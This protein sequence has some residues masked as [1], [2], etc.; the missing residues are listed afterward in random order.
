LVY[1]SVERAVNDELN[2]SNWLHTAVKISYQQLLNI[3]R[4][5]EDMNAS[6]SKGGVLG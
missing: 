3:A 1:I 4:G 6:K 2:L 5:E